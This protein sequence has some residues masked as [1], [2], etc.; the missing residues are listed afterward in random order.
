ME[1][2]Q[3]YVLVVQIALCFRSL[4]KSVHCYD[5][6]QHSERGRGQKG[7][8]GTPEQQQFLEQLN[9]YIMMFVFHENEEFHQPSSTLS[10]QLEFWSCP[11]QDNFIDCGLFSV[12]VVLHLLAHL[13]V[14]SNAFKQAIISHL[15][16]LFGCFPQQEQKGSNCIP[17]LV[18]GTSI[19]GQDGIEEVD[20]ASPTG[21]D[22]ARLSTSTSAS[23]P[24]T[25]AEARQ[26]TSNTSQ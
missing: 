5:S 8:T 19:L 7:T 1:S 16:N 17:C 18:K 24:G 13:E 4:Y 21:A 23:A 11:G 3:F 10:S 2:H 15:R 25:Q 12:G 9:T 26:P 22:A 6:L 20:G 14:E